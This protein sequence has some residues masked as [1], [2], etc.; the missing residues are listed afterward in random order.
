MNST[1]RGCRLVRIAARSPARRMIGPEVIRK[2]TP[3]SAATICASVVLPSPGGPANST[4]SSASPRVPGG[5]DEHGEIGA[6]LRLAD[7]LGQ[8][9]RP[10]RRLRFPG[11]RLGTHQPL[12]HFPSWMSCFLPY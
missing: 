12:V 6:Q 11:A 4:W 9:L 1:S 2:P 7:E 8:P 10:Q 3:S 5:L